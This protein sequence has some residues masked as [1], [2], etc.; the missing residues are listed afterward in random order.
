M[1]HNNSVPETNPLVA[2]EISRARRRR[3]MLEAF[4]ERGMAMAEAISRRVAHSLSADPVLEAASAFATVS[5]G[6]RLAIALETKV[7]AQILS[8]TMHGQ[9]ALEAMDSATP[10]LEGG[11]H[12]AEGADE[13][14][15]VAGDFRTCVEAIC[16]DLGLHPDWSCWSDEEGFIDDAGQP[17]LDFVSDPQMRD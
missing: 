2:A 8:L 15:L 3:E 10:L 9:T 11:D 5:R 6:V 4:S 17:L 12:L 7:D 13:D 1:P 14:A 16:A